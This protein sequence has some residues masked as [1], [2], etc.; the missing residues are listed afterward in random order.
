MN[1]KKDIAKM[2]LDEQTVP[3]QEEQLLDSGSP[4][5]EDYSFMPAYL[6]V[7]KSPPTPALRWAGYLLTFLFFS[8]LAWAYFSE[9]DIV[10]ISRGKIIADGRSKVIQSPVPAIVAAIEVSE[11]MEVRAGDP[12]I[13]LDA[14]SINTE[15]LKLSQTLALIRET[16]QISNFLLAV[17]DDFEE[18]LK[19]LEANKEFNVFQRSVIAGELEASHAAIK[20]VDEEIIRHKAI[21]QATINTILGLESLLNIAKQRQEASTHLHNIGVESEHETLKTKEAYLLI[22]NDLT[23]T[24]DQLIIKNQ[25]IKELESQRDARLVEYRVQHLRKLQELHMQEVEID[26]DLKRLQGD[27]QHYVIRSPIN[28]IVQQLVINTLGGVVTQAEKIMVIVPKSPS[29]ELETSILNK[30][31]GFVFKNQ[32]VTVKMDSFPYTKYG[33]IDGKVLWISS[34]SVEDEKLGPVFHARIRLAS[35]TIMVGNKNVNLTPGLAATVDIKTGKRK[36]IEYL[37]STIESYQEET[38]RER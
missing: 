15:I 12:L 33:T 5:N 21:R 11:G 34:D 36:V 3:K 35:S 28:G 4:K 30:D 14:K 38:L 32:D 13:R 10:A 25:E 1:S 17:G 9:V 31:V 2:Q 27:E 23:S 29:I 26:S 37:F 24:K 8:S 20:V 7:V 22:K 18:G 16:I 6:E 19:R